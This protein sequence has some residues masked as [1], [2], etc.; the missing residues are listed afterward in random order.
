MVWEI[1]LNEVR[2]IVRLEKVGYIWLYGSKNIPTLFKDRGL[3][4]K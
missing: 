4:S 2:I 3:F 1:A